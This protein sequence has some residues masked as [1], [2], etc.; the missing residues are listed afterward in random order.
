MYIC[1]Y[2]HGY[3][4]DNKLSWQVL[5]TYL[6]AG[7]SQSRRNCN[8][9][10]K[11]I[12]VHDASHNNNNT[13]NRWQTS[14]FRNSTF[15]PSIYERRRRLLLLSVND[16]HHH[17]HYRHCSSDQL[18]RLKYTYIWWSAIFV[19]YINVHYQCWFIIISREEEEEEI[20]YSIVP[21]PPPSI[22]CDIIVVREE[23]ILSLQANQN[24]VTT[25]LRCEP[26]THPVL[27]DIARYVVSPV[28]SVVINQQR[29][30]LHRW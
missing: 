17:R 15:P 6:H 3:V 14:W 10:W 21:P 24:G 1:T 22:D 19:Y 11:L 9:R 23:W 29:K 25:N 20:E 18:Y 28:A 8:L 7:Q 26:P 16:D 5:S 4:I 2:I 12:K 27:V 30:R 13:N